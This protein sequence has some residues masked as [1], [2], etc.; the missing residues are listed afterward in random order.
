MR[1][2]LAISLSAWLVDA[3]FLLVEFIVTKIPRTSPLLPTFD[4]MHSGALAK[5]LSRWQMV[6][7]KPAMGPYSQLSLDKDSS[8][9]STHIGLI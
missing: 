6:T 9:F 7:L 1:V 4:I 3:S 2:G 5:M 8:W